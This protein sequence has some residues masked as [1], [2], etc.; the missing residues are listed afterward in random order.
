M[1]ALSKQFLSIFLLASLVLSG[2]SN[3]MLEGEQREKTRPNVVIIFLDDSGWSDFEPFRERGLETPH[4]AQL[5]AEGCIYQNFYVPQAICSASRA[6]LMTGCYP[7]RTK[8]FG[9]H[10]PKARGLDPTFATMGEVFKD[11]GY[12]TA[13]F[14]KWHLGDQEDTRPPA[15][16]FD[17]S[18]GLMFSND[19]WKHHPENPEYW[20]QFQIEY[21]EDGAIKIGDVEKEDQKNLTKWYTERAT[22]FIQRNKDNPFLLYVPHSMPHVPLFVSEEFEGKSGMG[23]YWDVILELDWSIGQIN[24]SLK[25]NGLADN[26]VFILTSDNGP[27]I[28]YGNR[29]GL[30]PFRE[31]KGTSFD[32]GIRS[33]CIVKYPPEIRP[34]SSSDRTFFSI[35]FLPTLCHLAGV[36]LPGNEIDGKNVWDLIAGKSNATNPHAYYA[37]SNGNQFQGVM[38]GDGTWKLHL[39]H[40]FR[41]LARDGKDGKPGKYVQAQIDTALFNMV[42]D[43]Y[44]QQNLL[45]DRPEVA[46]ELLELAAQHKER[47]YP[48]DN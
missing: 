11:A 40:A 1:S 14:G 4:V 7:G 15:R 38:S 36:E 48:G 12:T 30:T 46:R 45:S 42:F 8:V 27:W 5:A 10:P 25:D 34:G 16:G 31:A 28:S 26:T 35:D 39:P 24:Q 22:D 44:E 23:L 21:W 47:F 13:V 2:C 17:E 29:A 20:G 43:P 18:C 32:G 9:A 33:A 37:F 19:M 6:S 41:S 3:S